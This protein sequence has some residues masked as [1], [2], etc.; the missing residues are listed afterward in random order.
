MQYMLIHSLNSCLEALDL[1]GNKL[2]SL[3]IAM[4]GFFNAPDGDKVNYSSL[5]NIVLDHNELQGSA[6]FS[7]LAGLPR[8]RFA[9]LNN[10]KIAF[11]PQVL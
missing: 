4:S 3:P 7:A 2:T 1:S 11:I 6:M 5:Q 8:L 9:S 10:N